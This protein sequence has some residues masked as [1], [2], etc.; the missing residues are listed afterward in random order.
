MSDIV[1][2]D[3]AF[4]RGVVS[5]GP[6]GAEETGVVLGLVTGGATSGAILLSPE[7]ARRLA[8]QL[9]EGACEVEAGQVRAVI[10]E[11]GASS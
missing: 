11:R 2:A 8:A 1:N 9:V 10:A 3:K 7:R 6:D 5:M 4:A